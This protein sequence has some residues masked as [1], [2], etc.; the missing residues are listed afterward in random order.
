MTP[1]ETDHSTDPLAAQQRLIESLCRPDRYPHTVDSV[2]RIETHISTLLLAG[3]YVYKIKKALKLAFVDY[4]TLA[5]RRACCD[6]EIRLN[7]RFA[8]DIYLACVAI[9][10]GADGPSLV[11][12]GPPIEYAV[13]MNRFAACAQGDACARDGRITAESVARLAATIARYHERAP[14]DPPDAGYATATAVTVAVTAN[15]GELDSLSGDRAL[16]AFAALKTWLIDRLAHAA[17]AFDHRHA[18][19]FVRECHGDMHLANLIYRNGHW[20]AFDCVEF[21][22]ALRWIDVIDDMAFTLMDLHAHGLAKLGHRFLNH[23]LEITGDYDGLA[24]LRLYLVHRAL[25]RAKVGLLSTAAD[26][27]SER[28]ASHYVDTALALSVERPRLVITHGISGSGKSWAAQ[29]VAEHFGYVRIRSDVERK[30]LHGLGPLARHADDPGHGLY[31]EQAS[32]ATYDRL[33]ELAEVSLRGGWPVILDA[34]FLDRDQRN[35]ARAV[36]HRIGCP[37]HILDM[38]IQPK[39]ARRRIRARGDS[40][41]SD[42]DERILDHQLAT[43][44]PL[45]SDEREDALTTSGAFSELRALFESLES[46]PGA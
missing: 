11:V 24:V 23:Y 8:P 42:A 2:E 34:T 14:T 1:N 37:F 12:D 4:G 38:D 9:H 43:Y 19:G 32:N 26:R 40:D 20:E 13:Q 18:A 6:E 45:G 28:S 30:R 5:R 25:V 31:D 21:D 39:T 17:A 35:A 3:D 44:S 22:A 41:A 16:P 10:D 33:F 15:L 7:R 46:S 36:A 29:R 27:D